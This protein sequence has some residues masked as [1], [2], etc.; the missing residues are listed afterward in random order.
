MCGMNRDKTAALTN[1]RIIIREILLRRIFKEHKKPEDQVIKLSRIY[2][3]VNANSKVEKKR[4]RDD[5]NNLLLEW[6]EQG[7]IY[8]FS[9][10]ETGRSVDAIV[11]AKNK[12][13]VRNFPGLQWYAN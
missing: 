2:E 1:R 5:A 10:R 9:F 12:E 4:A 13:G 7:T 8:A 3:K 6:L 11:I